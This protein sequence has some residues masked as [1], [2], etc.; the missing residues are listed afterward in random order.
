MLKNPELKKEGKK[1]INQ[2][3]ALADTC[4]R[5]RH[6]NENSALALV[7]KNISFTVMVKSAEKKNIFRKLGK[8]HSKKKAAAIIHSVKL[9]FAL[10]GRIKDVPGVYICSEGFHKSVL[11]QHLKQIMGKEFDEKKIFIVPSLTAMFG[12]KNIA[13]RLAWKVIKRKQKPNLLLK[14]EH[15]KILKLL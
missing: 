12:K 2:G 14:E 8:K 15:F 6:E 13:D 7:S 10:Q 11:K 5:T 3:Y 4:Q 9:Y 1:L